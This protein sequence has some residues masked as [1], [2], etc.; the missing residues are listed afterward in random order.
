MTKIVCLAIREIR[1]QLVSPVA[2]A[3]ATAYLLFAGYFFFNLLQEFAT[4]LR[5]YAFYAQIYQNPALLDRVNLNEVV[6][7]NLLRNLLVLFI[8]MMPALT[9]RSFSE[10]RKQGTDELLLT[11]PVTSTQIVAGKYLG[12]LAVAWT[13]IAV[14]GVF[15]LILLHYGDPET[16]PIWS[17]MLGLALAASA[18]AALGM[19]VS[20]L[21][22][23]QVV[24]WV[25]SFLLFMML[26]IVA[27]PA[28]SVGGRFGA[29]LKALSL[30]DRFDAFGKG[31]IQSQ[32]VVYLLS[33]AALGLFAARAIV[34]SQRWR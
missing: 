20:A 34:A 2:W 29:V 33:L 23:S 9:M 26:F 8:F 5:S 28:E 32:D 15:P 27:W 30:P 6:V 10:E 17:G 4:M 24:S 13:L 14:T 25:G 18:L 7:A 31:L 3:V 1:S 16:G 11:A 22:E 19:A 12:L 21:T